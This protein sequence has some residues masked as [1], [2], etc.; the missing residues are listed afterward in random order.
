MKIPLSWKKEMFVNQ[1][2][3][4]L[5]FADTTRQLNETFIIDIGLNFSKTK[6]DSTFIREIKKQIQENKNTKLIKE[7]KITLK[8]KPGF[9]IQTKI[10][11]LSIEKN[12]IEIY[13]NNKNDSYYILKIDAYGKE[14]IESRFCEAIQLLNHL[15]L[16]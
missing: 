10:E 13:L 6:I 2:E 8:E 7:S 12:C 14:N 3:T 1:N 5:Y 16:R 15:D 11:E 9:V 4:R